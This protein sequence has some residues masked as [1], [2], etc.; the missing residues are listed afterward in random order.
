MTDMRAI[1]SGSA[2]PPQRIKSRQPRR[3]GHLSSEFECL[4]V[5]GDTEGFY[6]GDGSRL[7]GAIIMDAVNN[8]CNPEGIF[9]K[10]SDPQNKGG[11]SCFRRKRLNPRRWFDGDWKRAER[12]VAYRPK[13]AGRQ[14]AVYQARTLR[15]E[16]DKLQWRGT[17]GASDRAVYDALLE[18][19]EQ[20]AKLLDVG[21]SV[22]Q[23]GERAGVGRGTASK[24]L[25][26]LRA[27]GLIGQSFPGHGKVPA[28]WNLMPRLRSISDN[29]P[30]TGGVVVGPDCPGSFALDSWRWRGLG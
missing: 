23:L 24:S 27:R 18:I 10:L 7:V 16:A 19:G 5:H 29:Q 13:L 25:K 14:E 12:K 6:D 1:D 3:L 9:Q 2:M 4:L 21:V 15:E 30:H 17:A 26:R 22:R 20:L 28:R 8:G 11:F